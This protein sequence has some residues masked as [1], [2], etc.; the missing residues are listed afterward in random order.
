MWMTAGPRPATLADVS[1]ARLQLVPP[2]PQQPEDRR[3][4]APAAFDVFA[5]A[6]E[7]R[8]PTLDLDDVRRILDAGA[9]WTE[10]QPLVHA[11]TAR[12][13]AFEALARFRHADG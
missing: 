8:A 4:P 10:Y 3:R 11:R 13:S 7:R 12:T 2:V 6:A 9:F 1:A 5:P